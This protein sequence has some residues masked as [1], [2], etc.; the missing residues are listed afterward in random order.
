MRLLKP[1]PETEV[2]RLRYKL[3][4]GEYDDGS[5]RISDN[6]KKSFLNCFNSEPI[7]FSVSEVGK[8]TF[9][10]EY[11]SILRKV[12]I[13]VARELVE[14]ELKREDRYVIALVRAL[15]EINSSVN[16]LE[17]KLEEI[18]EV[19]DGRLASEFERR[20]AI[21]KSFRGEI[22]REIEEVMRKIAPNVSEIVGEKLGARLL[23]RA[24]SLKKLAEFP[25][26]TIQ[27]IGAEKS[28]FKALS[29]LKRGKRARTPKH[30]II[31]QHP[32][33]K[34]LP[35]RKRGK[36]AR[37][38]AGK[39]SI[40]ARIDYFRGEINEKLSEEVRLKYERLSRN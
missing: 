34:T 2:L 21:L 8:K 31:F 37:F 5:V 30:G 29:R 3:W 13:E 38:M 16:L 15:D 28:L 12:A 26:S 36:M 32:F 10:D 9:G 27:V 24:G 14:R 19:R 17:E 23:E 25:A 20:I 18:R 1:S 39:I 22:E 6:L 4:F 7:P 33:I 35:R 40:G 11:Y